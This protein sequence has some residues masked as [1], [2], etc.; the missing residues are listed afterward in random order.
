MSEH[1]DLISHQIYLEA[2]KD[3]DIKP[4]P[5]SKRLGLP[6]TGLWYN[7]NAKRKWNVDTWF[8]ALHALGALEIR[9][10]GLF[11]NTKIGSKLLRDK[12]LKKKKV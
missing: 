8:L 4:L 9:R 1:K 11:I 6:L 7:M 12:V 3:L 2:M 10:G 5:L